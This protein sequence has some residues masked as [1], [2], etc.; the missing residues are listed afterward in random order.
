ME[1]EELILELSRLSEDEREVRYD[2]IQEEKEEELGE[3]KALEY[4]NQ[5]EAE[6]EERMSPIIKLES[7][8]YIPDKL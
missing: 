6:I 5:L 8:W 1:R 7:F 3:D 4:M 2:K